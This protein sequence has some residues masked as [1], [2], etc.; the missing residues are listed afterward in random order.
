MKFVALALALL[1]AVGSQAA[2]LQ[3]DPHT[4]L[5]HAR[6]AL[7]VYLNN[8][9][10]SAQRSLQ[11]LDDTEYKELK[12]R[13]SQRIDEIHNQISAL[14][15]S[16]SPT[17]DNVVSTIAEATADF[18][19]SVINDIETL[20]TE[21]APK[22]AKLREVIN[23]HFAEYHAQLDPIF[24]EYH[25]QHAA[26]LEALKTKLEPIMEELRTKVATNIEETKA[27]LLP[28]VEAVRTKLTE[29]VE[30]LKEIA[31]PYVEEY[32]EQMKQVY[33]HA[34]NVSPDDLAALRTKV[35][36]SFDGIKEKLQEI[37]QAISAT[38]T[39]N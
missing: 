15:G 25:D 4:H 17:T 22:R 7:D 24:K 33:D 10:E 28:I 35:A 36:A 5:A 38:F 11:G 6:A 19:A 13:L 26:N 14:R 21:L 8:L 31:T 16:I 39:P 18:R 1:L 37:S 32:K 27:A 23:K 34:Q 3:A 29:R 9:R 20:K 2:P 12:T 30:Q